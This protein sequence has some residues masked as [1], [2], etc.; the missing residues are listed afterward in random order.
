MV[1]TNLTGNFSSANNYAELIAAGNQVTDGFL[2][3][4]L[5]GSVG[6][7]MFIGLQRFQTAGTS[8]RITTFALF[9]A[10]FSF[11]AG[12]MLDKYWMVVIAIILAV[13]LFLTWTIDR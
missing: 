7:F 11:F 2:I 9:M 13:S 8:A 12:G 5:L 6:V 1:G 10:S 3:L 4:L